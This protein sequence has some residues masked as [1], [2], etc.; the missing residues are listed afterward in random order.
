MDAHQAETAGRHRDRAGDPQRGLHLSDLPLANSWL[1][2]PDSTTA[3]TAAPSDWPR[4][5]AVA[6]TPEAAPLRARAT[7]LS[8]SL[9][10]GA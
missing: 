3:T 2:T 1:A 7:L 6:S 8:I 10:L 9:L 5:R 4:V